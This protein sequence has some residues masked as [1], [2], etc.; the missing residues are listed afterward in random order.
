M[1][2]PLADLVESQTAQSNSR[3][4]FGELCAFHAALMCGVR[5]RAVA[6]ASGLSTATIAHLARAGDRHGGQL[7]YPR[8]A[9]ERQTLGD[10][11]FVQKYITPLIRDRLQVAIDAIRR[12]DAEAKAPGAVRP[13]ATRF[14][15]PHAVGDYGGSRW[16]FTVRFS[17]EPPI[18]W[19]YGVTFEPGR[20]HIAPEYVRWIGDRSRGGRG[21]ATSTEAYTALMSKLNP[22]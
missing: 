15:G 11:A 21:Y 5:N 14:R 16:E 3:M 19:L 22:K 1:E 8:V 6:K 2:N 20:G 7:R 9:S 13:N 12:H 17:K 18:G 4:P 10:Q